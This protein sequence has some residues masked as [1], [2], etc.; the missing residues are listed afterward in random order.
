M[1]QILFIYLFKNHWPQKPASRG[2]CTVQPKQHTVPQLRIVRD[3]DWSSNAKRNHGL[4]WGEA[5]CPNKVEMRFE[6]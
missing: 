2:I 4:W 3:A 1:I 6:W 5:H